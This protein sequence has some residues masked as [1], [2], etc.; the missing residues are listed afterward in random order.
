M[1]QS[2]LIDDLI[3]LILELNDDVWWPCDL[4]SLALI[5][6][7]WVGPVRRRLYACPIIYSFSSCTLLSRTLSENPHICNL[8]RSLNLRPTPS[9]RAVSSKDVASLRRVLNIKGL[10]SLTLAGQLAYDAE[11]FLHTMVH[12]HSI[13]RLSIDG[14]SLQ[15]CHGLRCP[16]YASVEWSELLAFKFPKLRD[17]QLS[18]LA[19]TIAMP[20]LPYS[21]RV[22]QITLNHVVIVGGVLQDLCHGSWQSLRRL[23]VSTTPFPDLQ[24]QLH[25]MLASCQH[26]ESFSFETRDEYWSGVDLIQILPSLGTLKCLSLTHVDMTPRSLFA[27][28]VAFKHLEELSI[29]G[30]S[31]R[32]APEEWVE[33]LRSDSLPF[34]K[35]LTTSLGTI[36]PPFTFWTNEQVKLVREACG[37]RQIA[38]N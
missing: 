13:T 37:S 12:G 6:L 24:D 26:L 7:A 14:S 11:R 35:V 27:I 18:N 34:L 33:F 10:Q 5:S 22:E 23:H 8:V 1:L 25:M 9:S 28:S 16:S 15:S 30:R 29:G 20:S 31:V 4:R 19:L 17:L 36:I 21:L 2:R 3:P 32:I 38:F